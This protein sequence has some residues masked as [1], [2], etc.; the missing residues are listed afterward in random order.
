MCN[1]VSGEG[2][3]VLECDALGCFLVNVLVLGGNVRF[4]SIVLDYYN[5]LFAHTSSP[6]EKLAN[7]MRTGEV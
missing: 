2:S 4:R 1:G 7:I 6:V 3:F 5:P